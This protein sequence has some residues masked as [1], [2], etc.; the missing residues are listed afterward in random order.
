MKIV[1]LK[2]Q[3]LMLHVTKNDVHLSYFVLLN[4][5]FFQP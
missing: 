3:V 2:L 1:E 4:V 5:S